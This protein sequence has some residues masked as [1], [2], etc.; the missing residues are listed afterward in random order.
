[1]N[2]SN[3]RQGS[4][5]QKSERGRRL[6]AV[7]GLFLLLGLY[8]YFILR[9]LSGGDASGE[10]LASLL[11][12]MIGLPILLFLMAFAL[13]SMRKRQSESQTEKEGEGSNEKK[14]TK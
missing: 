6:W 10:A 11:G 5:A 2:K 1:M 3:N 12:A 4:V 7:C 8:L 9:M 13:Q 14:F